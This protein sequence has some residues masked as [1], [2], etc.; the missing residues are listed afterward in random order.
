MKL[1][2]NITNPVSFK[3][4][5]T[6]FG[7]FFLINNSIAIGSEHNSYLT[8]RNQKY[9][10]LEKIY[11]QNSIPFIEYDNFGSQLKTFFGIYSIQSESSNYPDLAII[12]ISD[13]LRE[14]YYT[15]LNDMTINKTFYSIKKDSLFKN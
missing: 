11:R 13:A 8:K 10:K 15:Q 1:F 14:G 9:D 2:N 7:V 4:Y 6:F 12:K 5:I 3:N